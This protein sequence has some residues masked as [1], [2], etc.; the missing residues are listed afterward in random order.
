[1]NKAAP[2]TNAYS[3][4]DTQGNVYKPIAMGPK[5]VFAY[6]PAVLQPKDLLPLPS[7]ASPIPSLTV[8]SDGALPPEQRRYWDYD[9]GREPFRGTM[10]D[11]ASYIIENMALGQN[12]G[13]FH[14]GL[15]AYRREVL[16]TV[17]Y[18]AN[19]DGFVFDTRS[20]P[21]FLRAEMPASLPFSRMSRPR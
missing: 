14:S 3:I 10:E 11:Q 18:H 8:R 4:K 20:S 17:P 2:A 7:S 9:F 21:A 6:R 13:D 15:R 1:M 16:E 5:N 12:L 19:S